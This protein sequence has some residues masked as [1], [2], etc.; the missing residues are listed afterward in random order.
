MV[1]CPVAINNKFVENL[2][3]GVL[4]LDLFLESVS[5]LLQFLGLAPVI[6]GAGDVDFLRIRMRPMRVSLASG[7]LVL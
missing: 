5:D 4:E 7:M 2:V 6:E 1:C 3:V